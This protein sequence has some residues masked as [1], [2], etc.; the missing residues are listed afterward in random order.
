MPGNRGNVWLRRAG[1]LALAGAIFYGGGIFHREWVGR[2]LPALRPK[3][4]V[5]D[6]KDRSVG[7]IRDYVREAE[8]RK[9]QIGAGPYLLDGWLNTDIEPYPEVSYL[10]AAARFPLADGSFRYVFSE[11]VIEHLTLEQADQMLAESLRILEA[12]GKIRIATPD[13]RKLVALFDDQPS[14]AA[15]DYIPG[16]LDWH[17]WPR[18]GT[19]ESVILNLQLREFGHRFMY[20]EPTLRDSLERA[21]F[22][23]IKRF[24]AGESDDSELRGLEQRRDAA[25]A[26]LNDYETMVLQATKL[27]AGTE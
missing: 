23:E 14:E 4:A 16:K 5:D 10:D 22:S 8:T 24:G 20:D 26:A 2:I 19:P 21:G 12:G 3:P 15:R 1:R 11:H 27:A 9:L 7:A 17:G 13:L 18:R 6:F 25:T